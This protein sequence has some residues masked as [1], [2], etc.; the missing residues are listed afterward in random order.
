MPAIATV[1]EFEQPLVLAPEAAARHLGISKRSPRLIAEGKVIARKQ[2][3]RTLARRRSTES[4]RQQAVQQ[5]RHPR[6]VFSRRRH[7]LP[8][9]RQDPPGMRSLKEECK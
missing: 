6:V 5:N 4:P 8:R 1:A 7:R 9:S 2:R 3:P